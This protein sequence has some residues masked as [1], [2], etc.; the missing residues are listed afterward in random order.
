MIGRA[1]HIATAPAR[2]VYG[3]VDEGI[4]MARAAWEV[5][6]Y[7]IEIGGPREPE[8]DW[9]YLMGLDNDA[10]DTMLEGK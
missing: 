8:P 9:D 10:I 5:G 1:I 3:I 6:S 2:F 7:F 4:W